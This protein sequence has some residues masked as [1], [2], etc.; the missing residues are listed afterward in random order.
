[1]EITL[2]N[3][4]FLKF[5]VLSFE[6][7]RTYQIDDDGK[8][9]TNEPRV[10]IKGKEAEILFLEN[11]KKGFSINCIDVCKQKTRTKIETENERGGRRHG[12]KERKESL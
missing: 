8:W 9:Y 3:V 5:K 2:A 7:M 12:R 4:T 11:A 6:P 1:M 10:I